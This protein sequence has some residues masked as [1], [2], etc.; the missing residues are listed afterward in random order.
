MKAVDDKNMSKKN[1][2]KVSLLEMLVLE[3][4]AA[5]THFC[6]KG[7]WKSVPLLGA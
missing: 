6:M 3:I 5:I 7:I 1:F 4:W 2:G